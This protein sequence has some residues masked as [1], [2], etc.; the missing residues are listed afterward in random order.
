MKRL[1][2]EKKTLRLLPLVLLLSGMSSCHDDL[3]DSA[4]AVSGEPMDLRAEINQQYTTR[5]SDGGFADGD[6][7][8]V[9]V[10]N[11]SDDGQPQALQPTGN[12]A[13]NVR[14]TYDE[15][16]GKWAGSYQL[17]WKDK[18]TAADA[19][20]YYPF[21][22][23]LTSTQAYPFSV[24]K[25]QSV[26]MTTGRKL[27]AYEQSDFLWAK[28]EGVIPT[29]GAVTLRHHHLMAGVKVILHEGQGFADGEWNSIEKTVLVENTVTGST[30]NL[31]TGVVTPTGSVTTITPQPFIADG[32][33]LSTRAIVVP[34]TVS[35]GKSL[36]ALTIDGKSY[37]FT[38]DEAMV[39]YPG[40]L[41][42]FTFDVQKS[43][44]TGDYVFSLI[45]ESVTPWDNDPTSHDG[46]AREY[47][48][49]NIEEGEHLE[50][51]INRMGLDPAEIIN[52]K[53]TGTISDGSF[54][55]IRQ[56]MTALEAIN[57]KDLRTKNQ[58]TFRWESGWG[59]PPYGQQQYNDDF[60]PQ[61]A[62]LDMA[63]LKYVVWPDSMKGIG[64]GAFGGTGLRGSLIL[65]EGLKYIGGDAFCVYG[66]QPTNLTG[67]LYIPSTVEYIGDMAFGNY[68]S[69]NRCFFRNELVLPEHMIY[70]GSGAFAGCPFLTGQIHIPEGLVVLNGAFAPSMTAKVVRIPQGIKKINGLGGQPSSVVFPEGVEEIGYRAFA[71]MGSLQ[72]DIKLPSTLRVLGNE[73]F[74][75]TSISHINLPEGLE[76]IQGSTFYQ[77]RYLQDTI[78]IPSTVTQ[79]QSHAFFGCEKLEAVILPAGLEEIQGDAFTNCRSLCYVQCLNPV[80]PVIADNSFN[81]VEKNECA[82]VVPEG[83]EEAYRTAEGWKE[84]KRISAY[85][86]F[87]CRPMQARLLNKSNTR[88]VVLNSDGNWTVSHCPDWI[89]PSATS[90]Y[91]KTELAVTIDA[92]AHGSADRRD[93]I[94][95]TLT[96]KVDADGNPIT[97]HYTVQ[98]FDYEYDEDSQTQLQQATRGNNGGINIVFVGDGYDAED[99]ARGRF[100]ED[101][102][103]GMEYF[104][105]VEP[106]KTYMDYFNVYADFA[107]SYESGV[108]SN[109]NIWRQ[110]KF[111][112]TYGSGNNGR[113]GINDDDVFGYVL[114]EVSASAITSQNADQSLIIC[115]L[116]DDAYEG[117]TAMYG[118]GAA[119]AFVPHSRCN[120][121]NDYRGLIQ[122]EAG[123]HGFGKLGD[124][125]VYHRENIWACPCLCCAH[126]DDV[127]AT[128]A[129]GWYRNLSLDGKYKSIDWTHLIFDPRYGDI[130]D[131]YEGAYKHGR[132]IYRSEVNSCMNNNVPYYSTISRQAIVERIKQY[133]GEQFNFE[134]F[135][136]NDSREMGEKFLTR[137]AGSAGP[138]APAM[139]GSEPVIRQGSPLDYIKT[140]G[141]NR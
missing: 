123:G 9:F 80:P 76:F 128:K 90:G 33:D 58:Y 13:D 121:P 48:T 29:A 104:F 3:M 108:C 94:V 140:K 52:L 81:G 6:Q 137:S 70:L 93:S 62:F 42:Q 7:I 119:V 19:Y 103:E 138:V 10:V 60:L 40:K 15:A 20:G 32:E 1:Y 129:K 23:E 117:I 141:G 65:P 122:H 49:V 56:K 111:G 86:N 44:E 124:E 72:G 107:M 99:I 130:V 25:N 75:N 68:D 37:R 66:R 92:M 30:I 106:Y 64:P 79:I 31:Q 95:F 109:V 57:M 8:G 127:I 97:C 59:E 39:Y 91:K 34:Q 84:F 110:T 139:H 87:V 43:M 53:L 74:V 120:Y 134:D 17:Y 61:N 22:S 5:A 114:N 50:D 78:T 89:H 63:P 98:Q 88:T 16:T 54:D 45:S 133:A 77:C 35:A 26:Q 112:T 132:G 116:N 100:I 85:Q 51:I 126:A 71:E 41:H 36:F 14:F 2:I 21:D 136:A 47:I 11:Y 28:N 135:V 82:L 27:S 125:Y 101:M 73:A 12:H 96:D 131:I 67:D 102:K 118:S 69:G 115:V 83:S 113:L 4:P 38:R 18:V 55:Y 46:A 24:Q 105:A